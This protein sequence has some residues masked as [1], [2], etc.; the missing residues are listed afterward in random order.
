[1]NHNMMVMMI[2]M[3]KRRT[4]LGQSWPGDECGAAPGP[5]VRTGEKNWWKLELSKMP[6]W[7]Y[8]DMRQASLLIGPKGLFIYYVIADGGGGVSPIYYNI[9]WGEG[10]LPIPLKCVT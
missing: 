5:K 9:T 8:Q 4:W 1:M 3:M 10:G 2:L 7:T 6:N